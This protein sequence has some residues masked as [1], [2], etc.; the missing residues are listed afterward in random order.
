MSEDV[1]ERRQSPG[2]IAVMSW[3]YSAE[4]RDYY[5]D[6]SKQLL[7][8][9][10]QSSTCFLHS[11]TRAE[12]DGTRLWASQQQTPGQQQIASPQ[13]PVGQERE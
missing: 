8:Q 6:Q 7:L 9:Q 5:F 2:T 10:P 3:V 11:L 4:H 12:P 1:L 13:Q